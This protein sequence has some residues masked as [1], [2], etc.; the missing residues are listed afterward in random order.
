MCIVS[1]PVGRSRTHTTMVD[2][3]LLDVPHGPLSR[4]IEKY[5][6]AESSAESAALAEP[7]ALTST[8][9]SIGSNDAN[10]S[11]PSGS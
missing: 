6:S 9:C 11:A 4:S 5:V 8:T 3:A 10:H 1:T 7:V 2:E